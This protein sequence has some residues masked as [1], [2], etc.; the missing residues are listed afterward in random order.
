[1]TNFYNFKNFNIV[2]TGGAG[3]LGGE[4]ACALVDCGAN[5]AIIDRDQAR[6]EQLVE[7]MGGSEGCAISVYG[8]V[9]QKESLEKALE[10]IMGEF[11]Q[12]HALIN[13]AGGN[14]KEATTSP[15]MSFFNL[16][17]DAIQWVLNLNFLGTLLPSQVFGKVMVEQGEGVIL[18]VSSMECFPSADSCPCVLGCESGSQQFY[19]VAGCP[20]GTGIHPQHPG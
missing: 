6:A 8:D 3:V 10:I 15:D 18:N 12:I 2:I 4:M 16:P 1:L 14:K 11:G 9:L 13:G 7:R 17:Q 5:V 19:A 20:H